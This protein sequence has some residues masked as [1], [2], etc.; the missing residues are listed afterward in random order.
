M[1]FTHGWVNEPSIT[2][3]LEEGSEH[4]SAITP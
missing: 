3:N 1:T 2:A 4:A